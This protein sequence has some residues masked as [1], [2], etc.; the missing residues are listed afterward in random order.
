MASRRGEEGS[1]G[2]P[3]LYNVEAFFAAGHLLKPTAW[4]LAR[5]H[6]RW[7][8]NSARVTYCGDSGRRRG[9]APDFESA[10]T[11]DAW[12]FERLFF[13]GWSRRDSMSMF[14]APHFT[15]FSPLSKGGT[16]ENRMSWQFSRFDLLEA[17]QSG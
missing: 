1:G 17:P 13:R 15:L 5:L 6:R 11:N 10:F 14:L 16:L 9:T 4:N 2:H 7:S 8:G 3:I 12:L